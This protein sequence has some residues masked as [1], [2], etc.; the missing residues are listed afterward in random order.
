[1]ARIDKDKFYTL[2]EVAKNGWYFGLGIVGIKN[3]VKAGR[4]KARATSNRYSIY[5]ADI[6]NSVQKELK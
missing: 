4:L 6:L 5:G 3:A 2:G 1:M